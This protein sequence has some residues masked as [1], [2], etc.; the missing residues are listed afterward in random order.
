L[1]Y[2]NPKK[3]K[4]TG[5]YILFTDGDFLDINVWESQSAT[6]ETFNK[7]NNFQHNQNFGGQKHNKFNTHQNNQQN[8]GNSG[9]GGFNQNRGNFMGGKRGNYN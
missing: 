5:D 1:D 2:E 3:D 7:N 4:I 6:K 8:K 9:F